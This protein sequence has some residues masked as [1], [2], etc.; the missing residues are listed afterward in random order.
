MQ[1]QSFTLLA[2]FSLSACSA[3]LAI[4]DGPQMASGQLQNREVEIRSPVY[5]LL[6]PD[7]NYH[8]LAPLHL[9]STYI[10]C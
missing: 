8:P 3:A 10:S 9:F 5:V 7:P 2:L 1:F 6:R 4:A